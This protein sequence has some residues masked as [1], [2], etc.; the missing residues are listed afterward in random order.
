MPVDEDPKN[1][2]VVVLAAGDLYKPFLGLVAA[3]FLA[4]MCVSGYAGHGFFRGLL[5][6]TLCLT[7]SVRWTV[8]YWRHPSRYSHHSRVRLPWAPPLAG[9][10]GG[11][12]IWQS[13][14]ALAMPQLSTTAAWAIPV[15]VGCA[16]LAGGWFLSA[17]CYQDFLDPNFD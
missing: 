17:F 10:L 13:L 16:V 9:L 4:R 8:R 5:L 11:V 7:A 15:G 1:D 14:S 2:N 12:A 3:A 6:A